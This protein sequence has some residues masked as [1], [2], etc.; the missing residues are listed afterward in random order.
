MRMCACEKED[1]IEHDSLCF[2][3]HFE[4]RES[5]QAVASPQE[6]QFHFRSNGF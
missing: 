1:V 5:N 4:T 6:Y 2:L 3:K